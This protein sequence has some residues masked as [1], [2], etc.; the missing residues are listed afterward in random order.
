[1]GKTGI[2][3]IL[4][5][6]ACLVLNAGCVANGS[7]QVA[8]AFLDNVSQLRFDK[9]AEIATDSGK[10][11]ITSLGTFVSAGAAENKKK[12]Q[13]DNIATITRVE[14]NADTALVYYK[15][16]GGSERILKMIKKDGVWKADFSKDM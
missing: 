13:A 5:T 16:S 12:F 3:V 10:Q 8:Q 7:R 1:M 9:A 6:L 4:V 15:V 2:Q 14:E 11:A